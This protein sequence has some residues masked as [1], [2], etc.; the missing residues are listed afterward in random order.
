MV[1]VEEISR[2]IGNVAELKR[3]SK[4][5]AF[6]DLPGVPAG[7]AGKITLVNGWDTWVRY[8]VLFDN[9][10]DLGSINRPY[11]APAKQYS[12]LVADRERALASGAF[13]RVEAAAGADDSGAGD[14][15]GSSGGDVVVNG[16][17]VPGHLIE[18]S[19]SARA[20]LAA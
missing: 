19:K 5:V 7:T 16:V 6:D 18:R 17:A 14:G 11:L 15:G 9:G 2:E 3:K 13:D 4:V 1:T 8:R 12:A 10:V 20:R